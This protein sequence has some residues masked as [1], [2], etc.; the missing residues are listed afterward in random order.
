MQHESRA[1]GVAGEN[2]GI[3]AQGHQRQ[4]S[5]WGSGGVRMY[6]KREYGMKLMV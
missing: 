6:I 3:L 5:C 2:A 1:V 4:G